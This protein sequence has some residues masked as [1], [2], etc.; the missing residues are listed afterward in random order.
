VGRFQV[1]A[2]IIQAEQVVDAFWL[3]HIPC[4]G[5]MNL[6]QAYKDFLAYSSYRVNH[7]FGRLVH[8]RE[9][10]SKK[11]WERIPAI[12]VEC[13]AKDE[14]AVCQAGSALYP[15]VIPE[16]FM[17]PGLLAGHFMP[18]PMDRKHHKLYE[19]HR[20]FV[21]KNFA[22]TT[23]RSDIL[24]IDTPL[25]AESP[26]FTLRRVIMDIV[27]DGGVTPYL[28]ANISSFEN[29]DIRQNLSPPVRKA[30]NAGRKLFACHHT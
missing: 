8:K 4:I 29:G 22:L 25:L 5:S 23:A 18:F 10:Y 30:C 6:K 20:Y 2:E 21:S 28:I 13:D 14:S 26:W 27:S 7:R 15:R 16:G 11:D 17:T 19:I 24:D 1:S 12:F 9:F 3:T